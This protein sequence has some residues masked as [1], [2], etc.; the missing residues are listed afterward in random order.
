MHIYTKHL[1]FH[2]DKKMVLVCPPH[3]MCPKRNKCVVLGHFR[4]LK[5]VNFDHIVSCKN[6]DLLSVWP[7]F[8]AIGLSG[9]QPRAMP[10]RIWKMWLVEVQEIRNKI[11]HEPVIVPCGSNHCESMDLFL[12]LKYS[13]K[14][15][16]GLPCTQRQLETVSCH[17][18][19]LTKPTSKENLAWGKWLLRVEWLR[20]SWS[21]S[22]WWWV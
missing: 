6:A 16:V 8:E 4:F 5:D 14:H 17:V 22:W 20:D 7:S 9:T 21:S 3:W 18:N 13:D 15:S 11:H 1:N 10:P 19:H 2:W 12:Q